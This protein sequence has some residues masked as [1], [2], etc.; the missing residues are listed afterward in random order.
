MQNRPPTPYLNLLR[1]SWS[2]NIQTATTCGYTDLLPYVIESTT[3][4]RRREINHKI[5]QLCLKWFTKTHTRIQTRITWSLPRFPENR[6]R[7]HRREAINDAI[8]QLLSV[9][10]YS[11]KIRNYESTK[12][13]HNSTNSTKSLLKNLTYTQLAVEKTWKQQ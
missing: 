10:H 12:I 8:L 13:D 6:S 4:R 5:T 2:S 1:T 11:V 7:R 3:I 9:I